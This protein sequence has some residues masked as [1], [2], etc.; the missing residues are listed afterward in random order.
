MSEPFGK[1]GCP[2]RIA[3][4]G[5]GFPDRVQKDSCCSDDAWFP[6]KFLV[7][8]KSG[9]EQVNH[10]IV[11]EPVGVDFAHQQIR[12]LLCLVEYF[13]SDRTVSVYAGI[14]MIV[15]IV[16]YTFTQIRLTMPQPDSTG[17]SI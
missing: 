14:Q 9:L 6:M 11:P 15:H 1:V 13:V 3:G 10:R 7:V 16:I 2:R 5:F 12:F 8:S 17:F 4:S